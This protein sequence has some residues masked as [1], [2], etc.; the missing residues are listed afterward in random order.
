VKSVKSV[1][2]FMNIL[3]V[4][5]DSVIPNFALAKVER[6]HRDNGDDIRY[7]LEIFKPWADKIYVSCIFTKNKN[8][9]LPWVSDNTLVGGTGWDIH[10]KLPAEI[11][12]VKPKINWG[13]TTRGCVRHCGFCFVPEKE[14]KLH[15]VGDIYD[16]WDGHAKDITL[17]DNNILG[18]SGHF[19]KICAQL[20]HEKLRVDFNQGLDIR[21]LTPSLMKELKTI[22]HKE[23]HFAWDGR[24]DLS[25]K[26]RWLYKNLKRTTVYVLC[27]YNTTFK[28]DLDKFNTLKKI[29]HNGFCMRYETVV[30]DKN[31]TLL[32]RWVNQHHIFQTHTF[33]E[34]LELTSSGKQ[35]KDKISADLMKMAGN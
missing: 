5:I 12:K 27:G 8:L 2:A 23:Y 4:N 9:C 14:G 34:F 31:Y 15:V 20:R 24:L 33:K 6:Y 17:M 7:D 11:D 22:R 3:L 35:R 21:L 1:V 16:I 29:G 26:F 25:D 18:A 10:S 13:F 28:Q 32:A 30:H 19:R